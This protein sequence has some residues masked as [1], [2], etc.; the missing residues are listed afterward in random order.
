HLR[1]QRRHQLTVAD[2]PR[3]GSAHRLVHDLL[4][5]R[6]EKIGAVPDQLDDLGHGVARDGANEH[7]QD[8]RSETVAAIEDREAHAHSVLV[9][10]SRAATAVAYCRVAWPIAPHPTISKIS[11]SLRP[12]ALAAVISS[13][14]TL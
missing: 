13:S 8:L 5:R 6:A 3:G 2:R 14:V 1:D 4:H 10:S 9:A 7:E 12:D 11:S